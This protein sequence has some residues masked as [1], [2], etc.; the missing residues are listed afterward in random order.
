[1]ADTKDVFFPEFEIVGHVT[2]PHIKLNFDGSANFIKI[3]GPIEPGKELEAVRQR[4]AKEGSPAETM[5]PPDL[6]EIIEL[7]SGQL[8]N[9]IVNAV[10][11]SNLEEK[12]PEQGY[13]GRSFKISQ[14]STVSKGSRSYRTFEILE[15]KLKVAAE[16]PTPVKAGTAKK[17]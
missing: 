16:A 2:L 6:C 11:K 13:V 7:R 9:M 15:I 17:A 8:G 4:K 5:N 14:I 1:M 12:Y 10:I 3:V